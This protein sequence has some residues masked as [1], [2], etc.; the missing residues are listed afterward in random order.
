MMQKIAL[1]RPNL[2]A[3]AS[4]A[5]S[6][7]VR[8]FIAS[9]VEIRHILYSWC[10]KHELIIGQWTEKEGRL[11]SSGRPSSCSLSLGT[12][13]R[14]G[15]VTDGCME[16]RSSASRRLASMSWSLDRF[17]PVGRGG[18]ESRKRRRWE[19][20]IRGNRNMESG[21]VHTVRIKGIKSARRMRRK[22]EDGRRSR[23]SNIKRWRQIKAEKQ[24]ESAWGVKKLEWNRFIKDDEETQRDAG[25]ALTLLLRWS[26]FINITKNCTATTT[27]WS[28]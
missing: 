4:F 12:G 23:G 22:A 17:G 28:I 21:G 16:G 10:R 1:H 8:V 13:G 2:L 11:P 14:E 3:L 26:W 15:G 20:K 19:T 9:M 7:W 6:S 25:H 24:E 18:S 27:A 5:A